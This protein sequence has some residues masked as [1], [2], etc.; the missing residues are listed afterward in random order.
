MFHVIGKRNRVITKHFLDNSSHTQ[1]FPWHCNQQPL[2]MQISRRMNMDGIFEVDRRDCYLAP[3]GLFDPNNLLRQAFCDVKLT[4]RLRPVRRDP[5]F[6][7]TI[8]DWPQMTK[9]LNKIESMAPLK[10]REDRKNVLHLV[11]EHSDIDKTTKNWP[12]QDRCKNERD[13]LLKSHVVVPIP[14]YDVSGCPIE[15]QDYMSKIPGAI[16]QV[17]FTVQHCFI[18]KDKKQT[19]FS[20][21]IREMNIVRPAMAPLS[22]PMKK[23]RLTTGPVTMHTS[24]ASPSSPTKRT[25]RV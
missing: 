19:I 14:V 12:V 22:S 7:F 25:K 4:C 21:Y 6:A 10:N 9:N 24:D 20:A 3:D 5:D 11:Q 16:V 17:H 8:Q 18:K 15:P 2:F 23:H 13:N 1:Y